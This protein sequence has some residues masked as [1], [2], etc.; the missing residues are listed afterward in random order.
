M[1][2]STTREHACS[3]SRSAG[4]HID[5]PHIGKYEH[6]DTTATSVS[7]K[8]ENVGKKCVSV[9]RGLIH[10]HTKTF[11]SAYKVGG[12]PLHNDAIPSPRI[13]LINAS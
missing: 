11:L 10:G 5:T 1:Q 9:R 8:G 6:L 13:I 12:S 4:I 2:L 7:I 3:L